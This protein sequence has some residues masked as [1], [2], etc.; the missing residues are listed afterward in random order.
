MV[1]NALQQTS[2]LSVPVEQLKDDDDLFD[3][4]LVS[5]DL[6][7]LIAFLETTYGIEFPAE[8]MHRQTFMTINNISTTLM[9]LKPGD[10]SA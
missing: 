9:A 10:V 2:T 4:G 6:I 3:A 5:F 1:R 8:A 7:S